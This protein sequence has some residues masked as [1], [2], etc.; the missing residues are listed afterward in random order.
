M[1]N[2]RHVEW[3]HDHVRIERMLFRGT[4]DPAGGSVTPGVDGASGHGLTLRTTTPTPTGSAE[5]HSYGGCAPAP[6]SQAMLFGSSQWAASC[7]R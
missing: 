2:L 5:H 1:P 3:F 7:A 6:I 4:L